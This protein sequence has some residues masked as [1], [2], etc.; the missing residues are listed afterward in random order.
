MNKMIIAAMLL[1]VASP[2]L[3]DSLGGN[4]IAA[5][6][7]KPKSEDHALC[8]AYLLGYMDGVVVEQFDQEHGTPICISPIT[9][10]AE[11][12]EAVIG[13][14]KTHSAVLYFRTRDFVAAALLE[15]Y[16]CKNSN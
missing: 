9:T 14:S 3:A 5:C 12:R 16:P 7:T 6:N 15:T 11:I 4:L 10:E 2:A 1:F 13:Y 8:V